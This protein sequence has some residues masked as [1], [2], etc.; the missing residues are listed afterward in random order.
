MAR[1][2]RQHP[3]E[4]QRSRACVASAALVANLVALAVAVVELRQVQQHAAQAAAARAATERLH[5][6]GTDARP[7]GRPASWVASPAGERADD[8]GGCYS[9]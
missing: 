1:N 2:G 4:R 5:A 6:A 7:S 9:P 3:A 8:C